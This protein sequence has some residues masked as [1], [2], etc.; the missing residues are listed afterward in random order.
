MKKRLLAMLLAVCMVMTLP[1]TMASAASGDALTPDAGGK[2]TL[3]ADVTTDMRALTVGSG[4][5]VTLDIGSY[6]ISSSYDP[7]TISVE[8]GGTLTIIGTGT[9]TNTSEGSTTVRNYGTLIIGAEGSTDGPTITRGTTTNGAGNSAVKN[10]EESMLTIYGGTFDGDTRSIQNFGTMTIVGGTFE[11]SVEAW[12][13]T[14]GDTVYPS[15]LMIQGGEFRNFVGLAAND[16]ASLGNNTA[17]VTVSGGTFS[18]DSSLGVKGDGSFEDAKVTVGNGVSIDRGADVKLPGYDF[19]NG[20]LTEIGD[21]TLEKIT[22]TGV[23]SGN[24]VT[25]AE[26]TLIVAPSASVPTDDSGSV[27]TWWVGTK[28]TPPAGRTDDAK[29]QTRVPRADPTAESKGFGDIRDYKKAIDDAADGSA[30]LWVR[31]DDAGEMPAEYAKKGK[32]MVYTYR[33][34]WNGDGVWDRYVDI[35]VK[36]SIKLV[37]EMP[38]VEFTVDGEVFASV[39][40]DAEG[41]VAFPTDLT[42][43]GYTFKGWSETAGGTETVDTAAYFTTED[44][45]LYAV[46]EAAIPTYTLTLMDGD[47]V[48]DAYTVGPGTEYSDYKVTLPTLANTEEKEFIGWNEDSTN[49]DTEYMGG[50]AY[51]VKQDTTLYAVW[52]D[53]DAGNPVGP[54]N[55]TP[56]API[57]YSVTVAETENGKVK[58]S[59]DSAASGTKVTVTVTPNEGCVLESL[60]VTDRNDSEITLVENEDGTYTFTMPRSKVTVTA[61]FAAEEGEEPSDEPPVEP[62]MPTIDDFT[63]I[64]DMW[65]VPAIEF[66]LAN[67]IMQGFPD[68]TFKPNESMTRAQLAQILYNL[69]G[70]PEVTATE[71]GFI[72]V[73]ENAWYFAPIMWAA[74]N[75]IVNGYPDG[76][77]KPNEPVTREQMVAMIYRFIAYKGISTDAAGDCSRF[78]DGDTVSPWFETEVAWAVGVGLL[79]GD[80]NSMLNPTGNTRRCEAA[81]M[82]MNIAQ[83]LGIGVEGAKK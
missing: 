70:K 43:D 77:F 14:E 18:A 4:E 53:A 38:Q 62:E 80:S 72:D 83:V 52:N 21:G 34:D 75:G 5:V 26:S 6:N 17:T 56:S 36:P 66:A 54:T 71:S 8:K 59:T 68:D 27:T 12:T 1:P 29:Y 65:Y 25:Y 41:K 81:Q 47:A 30:G 33:F 32:D 78:K 19:T 50:T 51:E 82:F 3:V 42:K 9:I 63:D 60:T 13:Y 69:D 79:A 2:I 57:E 35:V 73:A 11:K 28:I 37:T 20:A 61:V 48:Y 24:T 74:E 67:G 39:T 7:Y 31:F 58:V 46:W 64:D 23:V 40:V 22:A 16:S 44:D 45:E 76:T 49:T 10:E 15:T 55:P